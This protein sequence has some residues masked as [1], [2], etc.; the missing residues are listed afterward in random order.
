MEIFTAIALLI[1]IFVLFDFKS[2][3][4]DKISALTQRIEAL[5]RQIHSLQ[6]TEKPPVEKP[7]T[8]AEEIK[9]APTPEIKR[10]SV[11]EEKRPPIVE[12]KKVAVKIKDEVEEKIEDEKKDEEKIERLST[13]RDILEEYVAKKEQKPKITIPKEPQP[14]FF[15]RNPDLEKFIGEN[16]INK[17]GIAILV[18]GIAFFVKY[19]IS[20]NWINEYGRTA[21]GVACG[22]ILIGVAHRLRKTF[23]AFSSV[24]VGGGLAVLY[25][26]ITIAFHEYHIFSQTVAFIIMV[27][28]TGFSVLLAVSYDRKELAVLAL[29]GGFTSP[30]LLSTGEGNH[31]VLFTY[32]TILNTGI[33]ALAFFKK[34]NVLNVLTYIFTILL[35]GGWLLV[36]VVWGYQPPYASALLFGTIFFVLFFLMNIINNVKENRKFNGLEISLLLSNTFLYYSAGMFILAHIQNGVYQGLFTAVVAVFNF[37][38]SFSLYKNGNADKNLVYMLIGLVLTFVSLTAPI[39][40][41]GNHITMF[42]ASESVLLLWLSQKSG[43]IL[44]KKASVI[45]LVLMV[46]S[47]MNDW[48]QIYLLY[49]GKELA[50][51]LNKGFITG[52]IAVISL[53][54]SVYFSKKDKDEFLFDGID[55]KF[56]SIILNVVLI[57]G[58]YTVILLELRCQ[59][60]Q[61]VKYYASRDLVIGC[62]NFGFIICLNLV[63]RVK[64]DIPSLAEASVLIGLVAILFYPL[65]YNEMIVNVRNAYLYTHRTGY[66]TYIIHYVD[67]VLVLSL[68]YVCYKNLKHASF[69]LKELDHIIMWYICFIFIYIGSAELDN[70][71]VI[72]N[73]GKHVDIYAVL[74]QNH[75]I[76]FPIFWGIC[77]FIVMIIGMKYKRRDLRIISLTLFLIIIL[78]L[79]LFDIRG[80]S[81][82]GKIAAFIVLGIILLIV[83]FMYQK[84]KK[85]VLDDDGKNTIDVLKNKEEISKSEEE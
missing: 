32:V 17:I 66:A 75:K 26:T 61:H 80:I 18:L 27:I 41:D 63:S 64:K 5:Q 28:I 33:L 56:Y 58:I 36:K 57:G 83:S 73:Y 19:A 7:R 48:K 81:E 3:L 29:I 49:S 39:Q 6:Q 51:L 59:L 68:L 31:V 69:K 1:V 46:G 78:K 82:G 11:L 67:I 42:W 79:F 38:F 23:A 8:S 14:S 85:L 50:I 35:F 24:L 70:I 77:S 43:I 34:W 2:T 65:F 55:M 52:V 74:Q 12:E 76:G 71:V 20:Q 84:L 60:H 4:V 72:N 44:M 13:Q 37:I 40:L 62:F 9:V 16:L 45:I 10:E 30:F 21:I 15:D 47:L 25:F 22:A 54:L 53:F